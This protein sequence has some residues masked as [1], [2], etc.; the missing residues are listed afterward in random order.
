VQVAA[1]PGFSGS[2]VA[3]GRQFAGQD[4]TG[5]PLS[6][7][8]EGTV[9]AAGTGF[10]YAK[11]RTGIA[12]ASCPTIVG[13]SYGNKTATSVAAFGYAAT[14]SRC[15]YD[16]GINGAIDAALT[17][18]D[19]TTYAAGASVNLSTFTTM[20][21]CLANGGS[22]ANWIPMGTSATIGSITGVTFDL[23]RQAVNADEGCLHCH[24]S[25][26]Q[27]NG[28]AERWKDT[29][30]KT[31]HKNML[32]QVT[33]GQ[34]WSGADG[35][36][37]TDYAAG[38]IN[39]GTLGVAGSATATVSSVAKPLLYIFGDW[40]APA[41]AGL[42]VVVNM[43]G[44]AK[45]N[46]SSDYSCA[47]CHTAGWSNTD[48]TKGLCT[49]SSKT[50]S[51]TCTT[52]GGTWTALTGVQ[53]IGTSGYA[54]KQPGDP[55]PGITFGT[56][57][58]WDLSGIM[59]SRC[60]SA[61]VPSVTRAQISGGSCAH[62]S[63]S[64]AL[65][66]GTW[67]SSSSSCN[68]SATDV[69]F[70]QA[71]C[72]AASATWTSAGTASAF[73]YTHSTAGGMGNVGP[74]GPSG[75]W[76]TKLCF[77]CHQSMAK[78]TNGA[79]ADVDLSHP[80]NLIVKN[81]IT[82]GSCS[83]DTSKTSE[84]T[85]QG[86]GSIWTP[87]S[88]VPMFSG[89]VLGNSFLNSVHGKATAT[90]VPNS[91]GKYDIATATYT[92]TFKGYTCW[93]SST[94]TSP[95]KTTI[96]D[97]EVHEIKDKTTCETL[98]GAG[99]WRADTQGNCTSCHDVHQSLFVEGQEGLRKECENCHENAVY[100]AAVPAAAQIDIAAISHPKGD[101]TPFDTSLY[102][103][104]CEVCHMPKPTSGDFWMHVWRI[105]TSASYSTFP[106]ATEYGAGTTPT[107]KIANAAADGSYTNAVWVDLDLACG[108]CHGG[109]AG[110]SATENGAPYIGKTLLAA[111]AENMHINSAPTVSMDI[112]VSSY[113]V[114]LTD[115]S[116]DDKEFPANAVTVRWGDGTSST[117]DAGSVF[118]HT[119]SADRTYKIVYTVVDADG[120][121]R[122]ITTKVLMPERFSIVVN[123]SPAI[124]NK[125]TF[126][127]KKNGVLKSRVTRTTSYTFPNLKPGT[128]QVKINKTG[129]AFDGDA[130]T[131]GNQ[132]PLTVVV[133]SSDQTVTFTH[134][135]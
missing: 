78:T 127:L 42:D 121:K 53:A 35:V 94:S 44:A 119:Y 46:G 122:G 4:A 87:T 10:C 103:N 102:V 34:P 100:K 85:C 108:Q 107:R 97:G 45:Y 37:Y 17:K 104:A 48:A 73:P 88:Y 133:G 120:L 64:C 96:I 69:Y 125:A 99:A 58:Q 23:T 60:H 41:P 40:M 66:G 67:T 55:F 123:L 65:A 1:T 39:W 49:L 130:V 131:E 135:P 3:Y 110:P 33:P 26:T 15:T 71:E 115:T 90:V 11:M 24:S 95:A 82:T 72:E 28:P 124:L 63:T 8:T 134:T 116:T 114:S 86:V 106:T 12:V 92:S 113:T 47:A 43:S 62:N 76:A 89:H 83:P 84:S 74:A 70:N 51:A 132:N 81:S 57:G 117:G 6:F 14:S 21:D 111:Y 13:S 31:G 16:Y 27:Y 126:Y 112:D 93:Q 19:G 36:N 22:W 5:T 54:A 79:G 128:Y 91:L 59:C 9:Q 118:E 80:E 2:C 98:Y 25:L 129:Y 61:T 52:A 18:A 109:S 56:A 38:T 20:G 30:L 75:S 77:G 29:Y 101:G 68:K 32:R 50:T 7:G 105:N